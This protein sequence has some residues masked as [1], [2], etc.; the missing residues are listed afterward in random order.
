M[1][2]HALE[3]Q[4]NG[5]PQLLFYGMAEIKLLQD[6]FGDDW[7]EQIREKLGRDWDFTAGVI[8]I[9]LKR[10]LPEA[11]AA[12][13]MEV[14]PPLVPTLKAVVCAINRCLYG[15]DQAPKRPDPPVPS[16]DEVASSAT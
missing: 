7:I 1:N 14:S 2:P 12:L 4:F 15:K 6:A 5:R 8:A 11:T 9:G 16:P 10:Y 13:V 3:I